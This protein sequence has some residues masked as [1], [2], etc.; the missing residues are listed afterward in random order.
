MEVG[1][2][3]LTSN[4]SLLKYLKGIEAQRELSL[5]LSSLYSLC[6]LWLNLFSREFP[7]GTFVPDINNEN[8]ALR[9]KFPLCAF[10]PV[11]FVPIIFLGVGGSLCKAAQANLPAPC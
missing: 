9:Q 10:V 5:Y 6:S 7:M 3:E 1:F 11:A 8:E 4:L 2:F